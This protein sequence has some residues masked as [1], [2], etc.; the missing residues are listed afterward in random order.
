LKTLEGMGILFHGNL[1]HHRQANFFL[2]KIEAYMSNGRL[3]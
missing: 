2:P 3:G 1:K